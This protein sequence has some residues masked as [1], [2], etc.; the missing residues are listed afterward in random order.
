MTRPFFEASP[1]VE[2][3]VASS[4]LLSTSNAVV[5]SSVEAQSVIPKHSDVEGTERQI[6]EHL[7]TASERALSAVIASDWSARRWSKGNES[8]RRDSTL[9]LLRALSLS[10]D[11]V[12]IEG[13]SMA[14][15]L[16]T[17]SRRSDAAPF[18][19][20]AATELS[21]TRMLA[22][23]STVSSLRRVVVVW[24]SRESREAL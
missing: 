1:V 6:V 22:S 16:M 9:F 3:A 2:S 12:L 15:L 13:Q 18:V 8:L 23:N 10:V 20:V 24:D 17:T 11:G 21:S 5:S 19:E 14:P 4:E 7:V